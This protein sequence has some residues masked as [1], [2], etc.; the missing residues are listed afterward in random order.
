MIYFYIYSVVRFEPY[1]SDRLEHSWW[2]LMSLFFYFTRRTFPS[3]AGWICTREWLFRQP[4]ISNSVEPNASDRTRLQKARENWRVKRLFCTVYIRLF[5]SMI[6]KLDLLKNNSSLVKNMLDGD[7]EI[8]TIEQ[9]FNL[10]KK[11]GKSDCCLGT[12]LEYL[13]CENILSEF[14]LKCISDIRDFLYLDVN[15]QKLVD[16]LH[17]SENEEQYARSLR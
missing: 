7:D 11:S 8:Q 10:I 15:L 13:E 9:L 3:C 17:S 1:L 2:Y 16:Y 4:G 12:V 14:A 5:H 6:N